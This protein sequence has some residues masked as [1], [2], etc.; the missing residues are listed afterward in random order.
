MSVTSHTLS[1][2]VWQFGSISH[3]EAIREKQ[4]L[5][6]S[7]LVTVACATFMRNHSYLQCEY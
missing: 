6:V 3:L 5:L 7:W 1:C 4:T 2:I